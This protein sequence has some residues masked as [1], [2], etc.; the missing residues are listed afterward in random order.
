[1][2]TRVLHLFQIVQDHIPFPDQVGKN[3][4]QAKKIIAV[5]ILPLAIIVI[6]IDPAVV[7]RLPVDKD[8]IPPYVPMF[9]PVLVQKADSI[10]TF[11]ESF[12]NTLESFEK[13]G[14][15]VHIQG[16]HNHMKGLAPDPVQ[17]PDEIPFFVLDPV[18]VHKIL[19]APHQIQDAGLFF[20]ATETVEFNTPD[21]GS[22][23]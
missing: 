15:V 23:L 21:S 4:S 2:D 20:R 13:I 8:V 5:D 10:D 18:P 1:M 22:K 12:Q 17:D 9:F 16:L 3:I 6:K 11:K 7:P 19:V 14:L